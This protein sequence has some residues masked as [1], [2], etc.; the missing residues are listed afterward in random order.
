MIKCSGCN[1]KLFFL[2][3]QTLILINAHVVVH[4]LRDVLV[5]LGHVGDQEDPGQEPDHGDPRSD[6]EHSLH[7]IST[8]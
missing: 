2:K 8:Q 1:N 3:K 7:I 5:V 6:V 4:L